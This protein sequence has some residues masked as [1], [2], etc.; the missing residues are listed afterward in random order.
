MIS[1]ASAGL[2][3]FITETDLTKQPKTSFK[4]VE[5]DNC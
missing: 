5:Y 2:N 1:L 3:H 4:N